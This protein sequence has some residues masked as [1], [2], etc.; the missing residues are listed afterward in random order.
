[1]DEGIFLLPA[2]RTVV[3]LNKSYKSRFCISSKAVC[4]ILLW[5]FAVLLSYKLV[6]N[7]DTYMQL[8]SGKSA[9]ATAI[10][11]VFSFIA[12]F[13]PIIGFIADVK[14]SRYRSI[15]CSSCLV[16]L[17]VVLLFLFLIGI[18]FIMSNG[19]AKPFKALTI[20]TTSILLGV[21]V[22][23]FVVF[24]INGFQFGMDQLQNSSSQD[25]ILFI[26]WYVWIYYLSILITE[27]QLN[28]VLY[29]DRY[30]YYIDKLRIS[31]ASLTFLTLT[32]VM[33]LLVI[34]ICVVRHKR[35]WFLLEP[36]GPNPY[37]LVYRV[38]KFAL[39]HKVPL[40]RSAFTYC[41]EEY[42]SRLDLG[43]HKYGGPFTT[44][45]VEDVKTFVGILKIL[46]ILGLVFFLQTVIPATLPGF[47]RHGNIFKLVNETWYQIHIEGIARHILIS[48][49][50]LSPLLVVI[51]LPLYLC[52][53]RPYI[54]Y[55]IPGMFKRIGIGILLIMLSLLSAFVMD[56]VV[57]ARK[58][59]N[60]SCML[61]T[62]AD[63][64]E[65]NFIILNTTNYPSPPLFQSV[66]FLAPQY[67]L[68]SLINMLIDIAVLEFICS[69]SPY[70]MKGM[71]L[72][73]FFSIKSF[74]QAV[75]IIF[76]LV[77]GTLWK[78]DH[79]LSCG[80]GFYLMHIII[81]VLTFILFS[82]VTRRYK[83][84]NVNEPCN[85]YRYAEEYYS[86]TQ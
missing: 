40:R 44:K 30:L 72:G 3:E 18:L 1:M 34:S 73:V 48:N 5:H 63:N 19:Y 53:I 76:M 83:Y 8:E 2:S 68:S 66:Y 65:L 64:N 75:A 42:P 25:L 41:E 21:M 15:L 79:T 10:I 81:A 77:F 9:S 56:Y 28:L 52:F 6:Y 54:L 29:D 61:N 37:K 71:V 32:V 50:V 47:A 59:E 36:P 55:H 74:F 58:T 33:L 17:E 31:G 12:M 51:C 13:S 86:N 22:V 45:Q 11:P 16:L 80:S 69:Q 27:T 23:S 62:F 39:Q 49:G 67:A 20:A 85:V 26:H 70:S 35:V 14:L 38:I 82:C 7:I 24:L 57:H 60:A 4:V 78:A 46:S 84:R 43:K